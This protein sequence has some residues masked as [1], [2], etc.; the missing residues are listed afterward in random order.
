MKLRYQKIGDTKRA[1]LIE[2]LCDGYPEEFA[3]YLKYVRR[4]DFFERPDYGFLRRLFL[5]LMNR[6]GWE[7]DWRF[8]WTLQQ[9]PPPQ[10]TP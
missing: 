2:D 6:R 9:P 1:T 8:D 3:T 5:D 7:L 10:V 4:L